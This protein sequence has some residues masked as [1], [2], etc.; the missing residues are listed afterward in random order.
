MRLSRCPA[1]RGLVLDVDVACRC[2]ADL[3]AVRAELKRLTGPSATWH[4]TAPVIPIEPFRKLHAKH[5]RQLAEAMA[6]ALKP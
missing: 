6:R 5:R 1:C 4:G 2:G 3:E